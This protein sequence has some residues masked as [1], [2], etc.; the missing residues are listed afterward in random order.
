M[1]IRDDLGKSKALVYITKVHKIIQARSHQR[2]G[3]S[4][5]VIG[6]DKEENFASSPLISDQKDL[7]LRIAALVWAGSDG[8][9]CQLARDVGEA[10]TYSPDFQLTFEQADILI[11]VLDQAGSDIARAEI[12]DLI[13]KTFSRNPDLEPTLGQ[14][15]ILITVL[16]R[17]ESDD[18]KEKIVYAILRGLS[19]K[20]VLLTPFLAAHTRPS[21]DNAWKKFTDTIKEASSNNLVFFN[22]ILT[23]LSRPGSDEALYW[24]SEVIAQAL[25]NNPDILVKILIALTWSS[26]DI[27][28]KGL[29]NSIKQALSE[30]PDTLM[31]VF[32]LGLN[33]PEVRISQDIKERIF[34]HIL[35]RGIYPHRHLSSYNQPNWSIILASMP[36]E[37]FDPVLNYFLFDNNMPE[38]LAILVS[39]PEELSEP[40][41][42]ANNNKAYRAILLANNIKEAFSKAVFIKL[43]AYRGYIE[44]TAGKELMGMPQGGSVTYLFTDSSVEFYA[45]PWDQFVERMGRLTGYPET[46]QGK[47]TGVSSPVK[48]K[49][50]DQKFFGTYRVPFTEGRICIP[51]KLRKGLG[52]IVFL[53][54]SKAEGSNFISL[55]PQ[56]TYL[57][58]EAEC[59]SRNEERLW[60]AGSYPVTIDN[61]GRI[62]IYKELREAAGL[63]DKYA[64][65]VGFKEHIELWPRQKWQRYVNGG[66]TNAS[67]PLVE[68][69]IENRKWRIA[70]HDAKR[71]A[72]KIASLLLKDYC[73]LPISLF[74]CVLPT[75]FLK[76]LYL[77]AI[78][79]SL[80]VSILEEYVFRKILFKAA[81]VKWL[82]LGI[83]KSLLLSSAVFALVYW[84]RGG[85][86]LE[87]PPIPQF[88]GGIILCS[89]YIRTNSLKYPIA[90]HAIW[91]AAVSVVCCTWPLTLDIAYIP[92]CAAATLFALPLFSRNKHLERFKK[93]ILNEQE[94]IRRSPEPGSSSS[95]V[96]SQIENG[97]WRVAE[98]KLKAASLLYLNKLDE[99][100]AD[101]LKKE[102]L[103]KY[104]NLIPLFTY[105]LKY[106][107]VN[108]R[109]V[110][111][112]FL[113]VLHRE[114]GDAGILERGN[115]DILKGILREDALKIAMELIDSKAYFLVGDAQVANRLAAEEGQIIIG[116]TDCVSEYRIGSF[117]CANGRRCY[118]PLPGGY[119]LSIKGSGDFASEDVKPHGFRD[120]N[121]I[122]GVVTKAETRELVDLRKINFEVA[123]LT[124][125][126]G[127]RELKK[128]PDGEGHLKPIEDYDYDWGFLGKPVNVFYLTQDY[129]RLAKL[130]QIIA[131]G[132]LGFLLER[133]SRV[134]G[135]K[136]TFPKLMLLIAERMGETAA[137]LQ[138]NK[139]YYSSLHV[140]DIDCTGANNDLEELLDEGRFKEGLEES[141]WYEDGCSLLEQGLSLAGIRKRLKILINMLR[142]EF[143]QEK[144]SLLFPHPAKLFTKLFAS[145]FRHLNDK[146]L[147]LYNDQPAAIIGIFSEPYFDYDAV[148]PWFGNNR[149]E[150][151]RAQ[152]L[153]ELADNLLKKEIKRRKRLS[154]LPRRASSPVNSQI[155]QSLEPIAKSDNSRLQALVRSCPRLIIGT[156]E[157][158]KVG[159]VP[160]HYK[161][162]GLL[163]CIYIPDLGA[164][165][166]DNHSDQFLMI[167]LAYELSLIR[168]KGKTL[169]HVDRPSHSDLI[170]AGLKNYNLESDFA[171]N[172]KYQ[173]EVLNEDIGRGI[174]AHIVPLIYDGTISHIVHVVND[175]WF[176]NHIKLAYNNLILSE[177]QGEGSPFET[178]CDGADAILAAEPEDFLFRITVPVTKVP[179]SRLE[180]YL[181]EHLVIND[182]ILGID[183]DS[184]VDHPH[185][186][187]RPDVSATQFWKRMNLLFPVIFMFTS[188]GYADQEQAVWF[189]KEVLSSRR[190]LFN[191]RNG[192]NFYPPETASSPLTRGSSP[193]INYEHEVQSYL[194]NNT[195]DEAKVLALSGDSR[196]ALIGKKAMYNHMHSEFAR[197]REQNIKFEGFDFYRAFFK[198]KRYCRFIEVGPQTI[199]GTGWCSN[200]I[201]VI[202]VQING[203]SLAVRGFVLHQEHLQIQNREEGWFKDYLRNIRCQRQFAKLASSFRRDA[204]RLIVIDYRY[205]VEWKMPLLK[206]YFQDKAVFR[207]IKF[208]FI[209]RPR[210]VTVIGTS[211]GYILSA[212][213]PST[214]KPLL[215]TWKEMLELPAEDNFT[216][217]EYRDNGLFSISSSSPVGEKT[218]LS[219]VLDLPTRSNFEMLADILRATADKKI[220]GILI[221]GSLAK[222]SAKETSDLDYFPIL[223][224]DQLSPLEI[225][226]AFHRFLLPLGI[227]KH[228]FITVAVLSCSSDKRPYEYFDSMIKGFF[229]PA[230][231]T[232]IIMSDPRGLG[233][234]FITDWVIVARSKEIEQKLTRLVDERI[235]SV[236]SELEKKG[237]GGNDPEPGVF[238]SSP[239]AARFSGADEWQVGCAVTTSGEQHKVPPLQIGD[240]RR[241]RWDDFVPFILK[242]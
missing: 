196:Q 55:Y 17:A 46:G 102:R 167:K 20:P 222:D 193:V 154:S 134:F 47:I 229:I 109:A 153:I 42:T 238:T 78:C 136:I 129:H 233:Q 141:I 37:L 14:L 206:K 8:D 219:P 235:K 29:T 27:A 7:N 209:K 32:I 176:D 200:C 204:Q 240:Y 30:S 241:K 101:Y 117:K 164:F 192:D 91:N 237:K 28:Q 142:N 218:E 81:L 149:I 79:Y 186:D 24:V 52:E 38:W 143:L 75:I 171:G 21:I 128:L 140:Q 231:I 77:L 188:P 198:G 105:E 170:G 3:S 203:D 48:S 88:L 23:I 72:T 15:N 60:S 131:T 150:I 22:P 119:L 19:N 86:S 178:G 213:D 157:D 182:C 56:D 76:N 33:N 73:L 180:D 49:L 217:M 210:I 53:R 66:K 232:G 125:Y 70:D 160:V 135:K 93:E 95:P 163:H 114:S 97:K 122:S 90:M 10:I 84:F 106:I 224:D 165:V 80:F 148:A 168:G 205:D 123:H 187:N 41:L 83:K 197:S 199:F 161:D 239:L 51:S 110:R 225:A 34:A 169:I 104:L 126:L 2:F 177:F 50:E 69:Q 133:M 71:L 54:L 162:I 94:R 26:S 31:S 92:L 195:L 111:P 107:L 1:P 220:L 116:I 185:Y 144:Q 89:M 85:F 39:I 155:T 103:D 18:A 57:K 62:Y 13:G 172:L 137:Y 16:T 216:F 6:K 221:F 230:D 159:T 215:L 191:N 4:P 179:L 127:Q 139:W 5:L 58:K 146:Y 113:Q 234:T 11:T 189:C 61:Q 40:L 112:V 158:I 214:L 118:I 156:E 194:L 202:G 226:Y 82:K 121:S 12:A 208:V 152:G 201:G 9:R 190:A 108:D 35:S 236:K 227:I 99:R 207:E 223:E 184:Y 67:S 68:S 100:F 166:G 138:N 74:I 242:K 130:P 228:D 183:V 175:A 145:Y 64:V 212:Q 63:L 120:R 36:E 44:K 98:D 174:Q 45:L 115:L 43:Q 151:I 173:I 59:G 124:P 147:N 132:G 25:I 211:E 96:D 65:F 181:K 87:Y